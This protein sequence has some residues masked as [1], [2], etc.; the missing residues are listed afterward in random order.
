MDTKTQEFEIRIRGQAAGSAET[1]D[2]QPLASAD[3]VHRLLQ[4]HIADTVHVAVQGLGRALEELALD[5]GDTVIGRDVLVSMVEGVPCDLGGECDFEI[6]IALEAKVAVESAPPWIRFSLL[7][8]G[9][10]R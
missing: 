5:C 1:D 8:C 4:Q 7:S 9:R 6:M 10:V 3:K 2:D